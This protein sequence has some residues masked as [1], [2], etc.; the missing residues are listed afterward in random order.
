MLTKEALENKLAL[1]YNG[2]NNYY[3]YP[4]GNFTFTDGVKTLADEGGGGGAYWLIDIIASYQRDKKMQKACNG[5]QVWKFKKD[6][7]GKGFIVN[8]Y[9]GNSEVAIISQKGEYADLQLDEIT[10]WV[11]DGGPDGKPVL[12]LPSER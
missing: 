7:V 11:E 8:C 9:D 2:T 5:F 4:L 12:M 3:S 1:H 10:L 6:A